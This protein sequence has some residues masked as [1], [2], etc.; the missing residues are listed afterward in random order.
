MNLENE[1]VDLEKSL[2]SGCSFLYEPCLSLS[3]SSWLPFRAKTELV[4]LDLMEIKVTQDPSAY[5][6]NRELR[7]TLDPKGQLVGQENLDPK[8]PKVMQ[9]L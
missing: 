5:L 3:F 6:E 7:V 9:D 4:Y 8:G 1:N 2:K